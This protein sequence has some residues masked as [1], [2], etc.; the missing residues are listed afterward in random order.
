MSAVLRFAQ[1]AKRSGPADTYAIARREL[2]AR[3]LGCLLLHLRRVDQDWEA[4]RAE[5]R[6]LA[7]ALLEAGVAA[8]RIVD[9]TGLSRTTLWR[10]RRNGLDKPKCPR[11]PAFQGAVL[12]QTGRP[13]TTGRLGGFCRQKPPARTA[14]WTPSSSCWGRAREPAAHDAARPEVRN[15][16]AARR[17]TPPQPRLRRDPRTRKG[18][19]RWRH[20]GGGGRPG[21]ARATGCGCGRR[22]G[23]HCGHGRG[24][25]APSHSR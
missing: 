16:D 15:R 4:P 3:D 17:P 12:F 19:S 2:D 14:T 6:A 7:V 1:Q 24:I 22:S 11:E 8:S 13:L 20:G 23:R 21:P 18:R 5:R 10:L 25:A 9:Q